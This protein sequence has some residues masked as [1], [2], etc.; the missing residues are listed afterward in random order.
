MHFEINGEWI[1]QEVWE[2]QMDDLTTFYLTPDKKVVTNFGV[3]RCMGEP[4]FSEED[5]WSISGNILTMGQVT[6]E[7][8]VDEVTLTMISGTVG[9][10]VRETFVH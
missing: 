10:R 5:N 8:T 9:Q 3:L 2:C 1:E 7:I 4:E 6:R